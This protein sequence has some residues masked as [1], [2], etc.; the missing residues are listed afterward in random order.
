MRPRPVAQA[1]GGRILA[2][3]QSRLTQTL[4]G[5][6][7]FFGQRGQPSL[8]AELCTQARPGSLRGQQRLGARAAEL[9]LTQLRGRIRN[10]GSRGQGN[11]SRLQ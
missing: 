11:S 5:Q 7:Q 3:H 8:S 10:L 2:V 6:G 1:D 9:R 4:I